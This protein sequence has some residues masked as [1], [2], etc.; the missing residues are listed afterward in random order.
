[1][2]KVVFKIPEWAI[3]FFANDDE[4]GLVEEEIVLCKKFMRQNR[5][6]GFLAIHSEEPFFQLSNDVGP[7]A[8]MCVEAVFHVWHTS[9][10]LFDR[11]VCPVDTR[12]GAPMGRTNKLWPLKEGGFYD[13][14]ADPI[15]WGN[16]PHFDRTVP[17]CSGYDKGGAY[18]GFP[19]DLRVRFSKDGEWWEFYRSPMKTPAV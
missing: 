9:Q 17:M 13:F 7:M 3:S 19:N 16:T 1:M 2:K 11:I 14:S 18:W 15:D 5:V 6:K 10:E 4:A 8:G 12:F